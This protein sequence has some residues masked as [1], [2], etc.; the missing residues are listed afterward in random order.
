MDAREARAIAEQWVAELV[1]GSPGEALGAFTYGSV[2]WMS[3]NDPV[4]PTSDLDLVVVVPE[5]EPAR[6][7]VFK[8]SYGGM[9]IEASYL[10]R[11]RLLSAEA[12]LGDPFLG[13]NLACARVLSDR[14]GILRGLQQAMIP[15]Y[16]RRHWVRERWRALRDQALALIAAFEV[17]DSV[18][19]L[20]GVA[21]L[22]VRAMA[23]MAL[24]ADLRNPTVKKALVEVRDV[25]AANGLAGEHREL[26]CLLG[27]DSLDGETI[28]KVAARCRT[29]LEEACRWLRTPFIGDNCVS[30]CS[31]P[32][33]DVDAPACA[34]NGTGREIFLWVETL[35][36]HAMI[37]LQ[38]D[39]SPEILAAATKV[40]L[41]DMAAI[42]SSMPAEARE[43]L[44]ACRP[45]LHRMLDVCGDILAHNVD[46]VD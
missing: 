4:P 3:D 34:A 40:Y 20:N 41:A 1:D 27:Y 32:A 13:P 22:A 46:V 6:H 23:Q 8:R 28:L 31:L 26:L 14:E 2:N 44:L 24:L 21:C 33:L 39:A 25:L 42:R 7:R 10:P 38:N 12:V 11:A 30:L 16:G 35:Y 45:H 15:E 18:V 29:A 19:Y 36:V 17:S 9:A 37:A 43:R 5:V